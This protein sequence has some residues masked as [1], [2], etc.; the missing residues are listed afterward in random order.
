MLGMDEESEKSLYESNS[1]LPTGASIDVLN[2]IRLR[3]EGLQ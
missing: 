2:M 3:K 1:L